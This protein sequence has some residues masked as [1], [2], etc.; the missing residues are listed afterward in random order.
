MAKSK[1][2]NKVK[3]DQKTESTAAATSPLTLSELRQNG[4]LWYKVLVLIYDFQHQKDAVSKR[5]TDAT[6]DSTYISAPYFT[7]EEAEVVKTT[8]VDDSVTIV[9]AIHT[10]LGSF[11]DKREA[12]GDYR[13]CGPH[14]MVP[15]FLSCFGIDKAEIADERFVSRVAR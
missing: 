11:T 8:L 4:G 15:A 14:D 1:G 2:K 10:A 13:P 12:S 3:N 9:E 7:P 5:R 6:V